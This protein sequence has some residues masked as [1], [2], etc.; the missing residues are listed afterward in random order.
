MKKRD[1]KKGHKLKIKS[2]RATQK[3]KR[4]KKTNDADKKSTVL[5]HRSYN[6]LRQLDAD[7]LL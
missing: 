1:G 4:K 7:S 3:S 6:K 2:R 5:G